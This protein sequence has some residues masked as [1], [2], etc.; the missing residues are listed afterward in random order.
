MTSSCA[1]TPYYMTQSRNA[2]TILARSMQ[3]SMV[4]EGLQVSSKYKADE[5][6]G[7]DLQRAF[8]SLQGHDSPR[9]VVQAGQDAVARVAVEHDLLH[10]QRAHV[11]AQQCM[12]QFP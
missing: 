7:G 5:F 9:V 4:N 6:E 1:T 3:P 8:A 2:K 11:P 10:E 12:D